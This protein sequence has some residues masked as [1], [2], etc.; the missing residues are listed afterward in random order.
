S[1]VVYGSVSGW[2][3][4]HIVYALLLFPAR[5]VRP[6]LSS[7]QELL[8]VLDTVN[9]TIANVT[10]FTDQEDVTSE[11]DTPTPDT[12]KSVGG[13][14][15]GRQW[16]WLLDVERACGLAVGRCLEGMLL[17][18]TH[19]S[20]EGTCKPWLNMDLFSSGLSDKNIC[21]DSV[22]SCIDSILGV[23]EC[24]HKVVLEALHN[25]STTYQQLS[26]PL[27]TLLQPES[28]ALSWMEDMVLAEEWDNCEMKDDPVLDTCTGLLLG[29]FLMHTG[30]TQ[31]QLGVYNNSVIKEMF[32]TVFYVRQRLVALN[33]QEGTGVRVRS[34]AESESAPDEE[35]TR[36]EQLLSA[37]V[38]MNQEAGFTEDQEE[39]RELRERLLAMGQPG[40]EE[41]EHDESAGEAV[42][43]EGVSYEA[44]AEHIIRQCLLLMLAVRPAPITKPLVNEIGQQELSGG[45]LERIAEIRRFVGAGDHQLSSI[46]SAAGSLPPPASVL[47]ASM[48]TQQTR[49]ESRLEALELMLTLLTPNQP[50]KKEEAKET[51]KEKKDKNEEDIK[52]YPLDKT[53]GSLLPSVYHEVMTGCFGLESLWSSSNYSLVRSLEATHYL[54]GIRASSQPTQQTIAATVH[55]IYR[56]LVSSLLYQD[57]QDKGLRE[58]LSLLTVFALSVRY[59]AADL[60]LTVSSG[61]LDALVRMCCP[62]DPPTLRHSPHPS[63]SDLLPHATHT[64]F[65]IITILT[66]YYAEDI[67]ETVLCQVMN[68]L[69]LQVEDLVNHIIKAND[70]ANQETSQNKV[71]RECKLEEEEDQAEV[72]EVKP[73]GNRSR[74]GL[75]L[76]GL[77]IQHSNN[78]AAASH[79]RR[80]RHLEVTLGN[81]LVFVRGLCVNKR[82]ME[83]VGRQPWVRLLLLLTGHQGDHHLPQVQ[84]VRTR[85]LAL[86]L[87][88]TTLPHS[89]LDL[90]AREQVVR[91]L[92]MQLAHNMWT[93]PQAQAHL[94]ASQLMQELQKH[95]VRLS[96][97]DILEEQSR[98]DS[99][100]D[101]LPVQEV[102]FDPDKSVCCSVE[103]GH[104]L[105][106]GP[107]GRGYGLGSTPISSGCY[108]WKFLI[109]KENRGNEGTCVGVSKYPVRDYSHR[110]SSDMWLYRAYSG[111][112][113]HNGELSISLPGFTQ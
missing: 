72:K 95:L 63:P 82:V 103:G 23:V 46:K 71:V 59:E 60:S 85:V 22:I 8:S 10:S 107:G 67:C 108:Q 84:S 52:L 15:V 89:Q 12:V 111:N 80:R 62:Y 70:L 41:P 20:T 106:H 29:T 17:G 16:S 56:H 27:M 26:T 51:D 37:R 4:A 39:V 74:A 102:G 42:A 100:D 68:L 64:L 19:S 28:L 69:Y 110:T 57:H 32:R 34:R 3:L 6:L 112:L 83:L 79:A 78:N 2:V 38:T 99:P 5:L 1:D 54:D 40:Y 58:R 96:S 81:L 31:V 86:T 113:Y 36:V 21:P 93:I 94:K 91:Q 43:E 101:N 77:N 35:R 7:L 44:A 30:T 73:V 66:G 47:L 49:A 87:L 13:G 105:V 33:T 55:I 75:R 11:V 90:E 14:V 48:V 18:P 97:P 50:E 24:G 104:T 92:F 65:Q 109:V 61:L 98:P 25:A 45:L 9:R 76:L 53:C 88:G